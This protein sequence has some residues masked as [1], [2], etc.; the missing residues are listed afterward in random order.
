MIEGERV[1]EKLGADA[2]GEREALNLRVNNK[3]DLDEFGNKVTVP[4][5]VSTAHQHD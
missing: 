3:H 5:E 4:D 1:F 2:L